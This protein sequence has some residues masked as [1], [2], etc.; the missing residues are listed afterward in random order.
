MPSMAR[1]KVKWASKVSVDS[2]PDAAVESDAD[3]GTYDLALETPNVDGIRG[4]V[5]RARLRV[6]RTGGF[7]GEVTLSL[8]DPP[9]D[10]S[11]TFEPNPVPAGV[12]IVEAR[13]ATPR[14]VGAN[15]PRWRS[16]ARRWS[17]TTTCRS[18]SRSAASTCA[19]GS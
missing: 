13:I 1:R 19:G 16:T 18:R 2:D 15:P 3:L 8:A 7:A 14:V 11:A 6:D 12:E 10:F 17:A 9:T 4:S 5:V